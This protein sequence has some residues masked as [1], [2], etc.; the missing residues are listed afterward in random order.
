MHAKQSRQISLNQKQTEQ[1]KY[2]NIE[3]RNIEHY[4]SRIST[5]LYV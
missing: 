4:I 1:Q 3:K 5:Y 2:L